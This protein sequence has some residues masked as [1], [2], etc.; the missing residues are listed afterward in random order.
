[1]M[2]AAHPCE[3]L[4][5]H[6]SIHIL[7]AFQVC[8][9][10]CFLREP[11]SGPSTYWRVLLSRVESFKMRAFLSTVAALAAIPLPTA[12]PSHYERQSCDTLTA[13]EVRSLGNSSLFTRWRPT[14]HYL[15]PAGWMND[16]CGAMYD[17]TQD[18]YHLF[19]QWHPEHINWGNISWGYAT[20]P[21]L[22]TW[23]DHVGWEDSEALALGPTGNGSYNGLGIFSGVRISIIVVIDIWRQILTIPRVL[24]LH[25]P[26][27]YMARSTVHFWPSIHR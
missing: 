4:E 14:Y 22:V 8:G 23:T 1:M 5:L 21:D 18:I 27:T 13:S 3:D 7:A 6:T 15:A 17:P 2:H 16:P 11:L 26:S 19:Y 10:L 12:G 20:S 24:R 25:N 9:S